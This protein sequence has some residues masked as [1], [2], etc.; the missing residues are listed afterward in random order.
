MRRTAAQRRRPAVVEAGRESAVGLWI[1][2]RF[3]AYGRFCVVGCLLLTPIAFYHRRSRVIWT[4]PKVAVLWL[5]V[6]GALGFWAFWCAERRAW[7]PRF[8]SLWPAAAYAIAAA[9]A[10]AFSLSPRMSLVGLSERYGGLLPLLLY[11]GAMVA[12]VGLWWERPERSRTLMVAVAASAMAQALAVLLQQAGIDRTLWEGPVPGTLYDYP[13]GLQG[14]SNFAGAH[15]GIAVAALVYLIRTG[16]S[17]R[18][19]AALGAGLGIDALALWYT[20]SRGG[21]LAAILGLAAMALANRRRPL[22]A[23]VKAGA[24][25]GA[26]AVLLAGTL[27]G[28][29]ADSGAPSGEAAETD[30]LRTRTLDLRLTYWA[31]ALRILADHPIVG[32]G[33]DTFYA[34]YPAYRPAS[35]GSGLDARIGVD[36]PHNVV[37]ERATD[38]GVLGLAA[39]LCVVALALLYGYRRCRVATGHERALLA[40]FLGLLCAYLAQAAV[41]ID[42]PSLALTGWVAVG[43]VVVLADPSLVRAREAPAPG[44]ARAARRTGR[45]SRASF[46]RRTALVLA[47][48]A[49]LG[50][51]VVGLAPL[52][53]DIAAQDGRFAD[54]ARLDPASTDARV[55]A[56]RRAQLTG[57]ASPD[58]DQKRR[59]L[60]EARRR[61]LNALA[62]KPRDPRALLGLAA[63]ETAWAS[64]VDPARF[65]DARRWW[66]Q[67]M[68]NDPNNLLLRQAHARELPDAVRATVTRLEAEAQVRRQDSATRVDLAYAYLAQGDSARARAAIEEAARL[69][70]TNRR[71]RS[72]LA[73]LPPP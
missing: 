22:R 38:S 70:P 52:R 71:A 40:A 47:V 11:I 61:Y 37:L 58:A 59:L 66:Q 21:M 41:S 13:P 26:V 28:L 1:A 69:D 30:L 55:A 68:A 6:L 73:S 17:R 33:L 36:K 53:A 23:W 64:G 46:A 10:T 56:A 67:A 49:A 9:I 42:Q 20:R 15:L 72:L 50:A 8:R 24:A 18:W 16:R 7:P 54:A 51:G 57:A 48:P 39:Y 25:A 19:R 63:V 4:T 27:I 34:Y 62:L 35:D 29:R 32:T 12:L 43:G 5:A 14:H 44:P 3:G 2:E 65:A 45:R 31:A 60:D